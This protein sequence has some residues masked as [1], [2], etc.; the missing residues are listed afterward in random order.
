MATAE[1]QRL[2]ETQTIREGLG[3]VDLAQH[4]IQGSNRISKRT[5]AAKTTLQ[6]VFLSSFQSLVSW[7]DL[8]Y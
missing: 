3:L 2:K 8:P 5:I 6:I 7:I 1:F 4:G